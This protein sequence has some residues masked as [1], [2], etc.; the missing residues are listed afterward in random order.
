MASREG[1]SKVEDRALM[2]GWAWWWRGKVTALGK[3]FRQIA[4]N[5]SK[6]PK[7]WRRHRCENDLVA[8]FRDQ[9]LVTLETES[10]RQPDGLAA[11]MLKNFRGLHSYRL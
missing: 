3:L 7:L 4:P 9:N 5:L 10:L 2:G 6:R 11:P 1:R 8:L